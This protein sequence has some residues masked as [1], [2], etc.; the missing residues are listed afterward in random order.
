MNESLEI[1]YEDED[2]LVVNKPPGLVCHPTKPDG[3]SSLIACLRAH[4]GPGATPSMVNRL[5]RE[6]S[7]LVLVAKT[8]AAA[9]ELGRL[10]EQR[11]VEKAYLGIV[12]GHPAQ[13]QGRIEAPLGR[14]PDALVA[15][16][17]TVRPDGAPAITEFHVLCRFV[18]PVP[19]R[20]DPRWWKDSEPAQ[21]VGGANPAAPDGPPQPFSLLRLRPRTGRKHQ[22]R[23]HLAHLGHPIVGDK[24][25]GGD[26][27][28]YLDFVLGRLTAIQQARLILPHHALHA[29]ELSFC[30]R[31]RRWHF[32]AP[33]PTTF[34]Q[35]LADAGVAL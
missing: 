24:L 1:L 22:L 2:L 8:R 11:A 28:L 25:Y 10:T 12:H 9:S 23:I 4:L 35:F 5:D 30:W 20:P 7:G 29:A 19:D 17:D 26:P 14:D 15:I 33:A 27:S 6:T 18:R 31:G 3:R 16:Q 34:R 21:E 32:T 13:D